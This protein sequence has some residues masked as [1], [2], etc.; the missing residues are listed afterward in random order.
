MPGEALRV[1]RPTSVA[2]TSG[3]HH[4]RGR[5]DRLRIERPRHHSDE[6]QL[7]IANG[8]TTPRGGIGPDREEPLGRQDAQAPLVGLLRSHRAPALHDLD[9]AEDVRDLLGG[10]EGQRGVNLWRGSQ[11]KNHR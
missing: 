1:D 10:Q 6:P 2:C 11:P 5:E 8:R 4:S 7:T 9:E 3:A